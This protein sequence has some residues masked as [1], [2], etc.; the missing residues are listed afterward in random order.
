MIL[1][2]LQALLLTALAV[3]LVLVGAYATGG[4]KARAAAR[5][6]AEKLRRASETAASEARRTSA[7]TRHAIE[8]AI[9]ADP[10]SA[11]ER[12]RRDWT[13]D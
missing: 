13:R 1:G 9:R 7:E 6:E 10:S 8:E 5:L 2:R 3:F 11:T 4:A 12:L